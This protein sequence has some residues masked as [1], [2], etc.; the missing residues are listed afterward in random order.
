M[1]LLWRSHAGTLS[2][3]HDRGSDV[4]IGSEDYIGSWHCDLNE[5]DQPNVHMPNFDN[6]IEET[7]AKR[8]R[9]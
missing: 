3:H 2:Y 4:D 8:A 5:G 6:A 9:K 7:S 1:G